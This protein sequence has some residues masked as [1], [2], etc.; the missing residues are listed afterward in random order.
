[1]TQREA[2][3]AGKITPAMEAA[4]AKEGLAPEIIRQGVARGTLVIPANFL[5]RHLDPIAIGAGV[6][7]KINANLGTSPH[8]VDLAKERQKLAAALR[9]GADTIMDLST[10]GDLD[11]IRQALW[12]ECRVPFGTVPIYQVMAEARS[13]EEVQAADILA[14]VRKHAEQ[15]VDFV[16]VHCGITRRALPLLQNRVMGVVSRGGAFL[17]AWMRRFKREN[18]LY[19]YF[20]DLLA[21][22]RQYDVT[23][24]LGDG[25]RPGCLADAN[26]RA[27]FQELR[28]LGKLTARAWAAGVQVIIEGPGHVPFHLI[29]KN[30]RLQQKYC[31]GAPFYVLGP[32][33]TDVAA[34]YDHIA[35]AIGGTLAASLGAAFL[36]YL[37]P[38]E[39][40]KL[41]E[42]QDVIDG[43]VASRI[44][45]HAAD[46]ARGLPGAAAWDL[47]MSQARRALDWPTQIALSV[48]PDKAKQYREQSRI[49]EDQC[50]MCGRFCAIKIFDDRFADWEPSLGKKPGLVE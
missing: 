7:V 1:M 2:A 11:A 8:E 48:N 12:Q 16:T 29:K 37:T 32:L 47:K 36:C 21:I 6:R 33:V 28:L 30:I 19:E 25:L 9:Y 4:A 20:D 39:H 3:V 34:G 31:H 40:L 46:L 35:G 17:V 44:A 24:S 13:L 15:G 14:A 45:A 10:G 27:Q 42:V 49:Q 23:L 22:A 18:P 38:A 5:H 41:P 43:V 50:T 26:D